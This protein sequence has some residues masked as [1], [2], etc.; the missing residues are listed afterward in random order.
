MGLFPRT[1]RTAL[2]LFCRLNRCGTARA[3]E[4][5]TS[6]MPQVWRTDCI[7]GDVARSEISEGSLPK[8]QRNQVIGNQTLFDKKFEGKSRSLLYEITIM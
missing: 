1:L 3:T 8:R 4:C 6:A 7:A 5:S 2:A